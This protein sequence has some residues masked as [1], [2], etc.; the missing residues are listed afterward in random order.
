MGKNSTF[1]QKKCGK[2]NWSAY[3]TELEKN[4]M[5]TMFTIRVAAERSIA[6]AARPM[7]AAAMRPERPVD[8][9]FS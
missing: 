5:T 4:Y 8:T 9:I 1:F 3:N 6:M 7:V 2:K